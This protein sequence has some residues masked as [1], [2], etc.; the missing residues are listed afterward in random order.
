MVKI[1]YTPTIHDRFGDSS[2]AI[3]MAGINPWMIFLMQPIFVQYLTPYRHETILKCGSLL[4][5][6]GFFGFGMY[7]PLFACMLFL[8]IMTIG[9]M[10]F[11]PMSKYLSILCFENGAEGVAMSYWKLT[12]LLS[13]TLG[14]YFSGFMVF[15]WGLTSI[16]IGALLIGAIASMIYSKWQWET[17]SVIPSV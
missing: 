3:V 2:T 15:E 8:M 16:W 4:I 12:Y 9:E 7:S 1:G 5:G 11:S 17:N 14:T 10:M 13:G 6:L